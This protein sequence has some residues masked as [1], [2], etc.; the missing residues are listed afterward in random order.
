MIWRIVVG[1]LLLVSGMLA[2]LVIYVFGH[3][4]Y[5]PDK[6]VRVWP[7]LVWAGVGAAVLLSLLF[8]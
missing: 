8:W 5:S 3:I 6:V 7:A 2:A 1:L 4:D